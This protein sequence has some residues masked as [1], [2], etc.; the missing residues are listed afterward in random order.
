M[1]IGIAKDAVITAI[2]R[3]GEVRTCSTTGHSVSKTH[4][5]LTQGTSRMLLCDVEIVLLVK[6]I[7]QCSTKNGTPPSWKLTS[8]P[9]A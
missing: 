2:T 8:I 3:K 6:E 5:P 7:L 1:N 9:N 4:R